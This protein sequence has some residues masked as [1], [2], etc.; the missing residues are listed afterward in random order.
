MTQTRYLCTFWLLLSL[1]TIDT[2]RAE[3]P[4]ACVDNTPH[5]ERFVTVAPNVNLH[6]MDWGGT[7]ETMLLLTGLGDNAHVYSQFAFQWNDHFH[8]IGITR[9]GYLPSSQPADGYDVATRVADDIAV[10]DFLKISTVVLVGHSIAGSELSALAASHPD[11]VDKLVYF[12]ALDLSQ[13]N[14]VRGPPAFTGLFTD[15]DTKTLWSYAA[16]NARYQGVRES[17]PAICPGLQFDNVGNPVASTTPDAVPA[18]IQAGIAAIP[19]VN[20][21][22]I[23]APRLGVFAQP[24]LEVRAPWFTYLSQADQALF[25]EQYPAYVD[26]YKRTMRQF[27]RGN[28]VPSVI[29][30]NAPHYVYINNETD[31]VRAMRDFLG[32]Q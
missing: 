16:A 23:E 18:A 32:I 17:E 29:L 8:V 20:W 7:G 19:L 15:A 4:P 28:P 25:D 1:C 27:T 10:L 6:V 9:R 13:R 5:T 30:K 2:T 22:R 31:V 26:W 14:T 12:D 24:T 3:A 21:S 11:R